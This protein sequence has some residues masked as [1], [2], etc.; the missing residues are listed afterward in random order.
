M[1]LSGVRKWARRDWLTQGRQVNNGACRGAKSGST[2]PLSA[3]SAQK[4]ATVAA[5][6]VAMPALPI[7]VGSAAAIV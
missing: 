2:P 4:Y 3:V 1:L 7:N 6:P 5:D